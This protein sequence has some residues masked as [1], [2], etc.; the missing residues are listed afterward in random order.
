MA[1]SFVGSGSSDGTTVTIPV[2]HQNG[3]LLVIFGALMTAN[4]GVSLP[5]GW[6]SLVNT[7]NS[8]PNISARLGFK[9]AGSSAETSGT[10]TGATGL[11]VAVYRGVSTSRA[12]ANSTNT[13]QWIITSSNLRFVNGITPLSFAEPGAS[14]L[15]SFAIGTTTTV[16]MT[17]QFAG[18]T[19]RTNGIGAST[20]YI[21]DDSNGTYPSTGSLA[22]AATNVTLSGSINQATA[23]CEVFT[24]HLKDFNNYQFVKAGNGMSVTEKIR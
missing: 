24:E 2:G 1:M 6:S 8:G 12:A 4:S 15:L 3:D 22:A 10:W 17:G 21:A 19:N 5:A 7:N 23:S 11:V 14:W 20:T 9:I 16:D 18:M 13:S